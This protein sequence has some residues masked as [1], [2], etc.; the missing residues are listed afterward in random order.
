MAQSS[1]FEQPEKVVEISRVVNRYRQL[2]S[3]AFVNSFATCLGLKVAVDYPHTGPAHMPTYQAVLNVGGE[4]F[5][6]QGADKRSAKT[7]ACGQ[8]LARAIGVAQTTIRKTEANDCGKQYCGACECW[9]NPDGHEA[10]CRP[11]RR[12]V[13]EWYALQHPTR[14]YAEDHYVG[15]QEWNFMVSVICKRTGAIVSELATVGYKSAKYQAVL[16]REIMLDAGCDENTSD[17]SR[18]DLLEATFLC[19]SG[20]RSSA[21]ARLYRDVFKDKLNVDVAISE[22]EKRKLMGYKLF[23]FE[24]A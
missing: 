3:D 18:G 2:A 23:D 8:V 10:R 16:W 4:K 22:E 15:D 24:Q 13:S 7:A 6:A 1:I 14:N 20:F 19:D 11:A 5:V 9:I 21:I 12:H 17:H